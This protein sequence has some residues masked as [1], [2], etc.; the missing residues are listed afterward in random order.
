MGVVET[1]YGRIGLVICADTFVDA[2]AARIVQLR[3]DL[4][5]LPCGWAAEVDKWVD[6]AKRLEALIV[7]TAG[8]TW[9]RASIAV[10]ASGRVLALLRVRDVEVRVIDVPVGVRRGGS[11]RLSK[12]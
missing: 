6:H 7:R 12:K 2:V 9:G 4:M 10:D 5:L 11:A 1:V 8:R 3:P